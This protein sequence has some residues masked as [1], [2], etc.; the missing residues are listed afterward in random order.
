MLKG[1]PGRK[2]R[3]EIDLDAVAH[4]IALLRD[5]AGGAGVIFPVKA[6]GYGHGMIEVARRAVTEGVTLLA[7]ANAQ[8]LF[9]LRELDID[10]PTLILEDLFD[11]ELQAAVQD[12]GAR[13]NVSSPEYAQKLSAAAARR[14][15]SREVAT[16]G[17]IKVHVNIDTG[18]GRMGLLSPDPVAAVREISTLPGIEIEGIFSHFPAA[19]EADTSFAGEQLRSFRDLLR[20]LEAEGVRPRFSHIANSAGIITFGKESAFDLIRPGVS[21]YGMFPSR[22]V[23]EKMVD[24]LELRPV[25]TLLSAVVKVTRYDRPWTVGYGRS[26][27]VGPGSRIAV[28]P[29]GYG[30][31]YRRAL[32]NN[33]AVV[34]HGR[35]LPVVGRVS[36][37]MI[38]VDT[39]DLPEDVAPGDE[40][41]LI[42]TQKWRDRRATVTAE[43]MA[44]QVGT[45]SYEISCGFT[46][47]IPRIY[48]PRA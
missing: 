46:S 13:F 4:N 36:M 33:G 45:I 12:A 18:M 28:I 15:E 20:R 16:L 1:L 23:A 2:T 42:G 30:D 17:P 10:H 3:A 43:E 29:V 21:A 25:L 37:D 26:Y 44:E 35:R 40:V 39:T 48:R 38:T 5:A 34:L 22:Q 24:R 7:V 32:S 31:G 19:D 11:E 27:T 9:R 6:D 14:G 47:R 8:E 41:V